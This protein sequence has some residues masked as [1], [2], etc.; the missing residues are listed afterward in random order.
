MQDRKAQPNKVMTMA[1]PYLKQI[2]I[3]LY[4]N[5]AETVVNLQP[6]LTVLVGPNGA[7]K[8]NF[9]DALSFVADCLNYSIQLAFAN[10]GGPT[11]VR[12]KSDQRPIN[13][14]L[15]F[16]IDFGD[17]GWAD[18]AFE[19]QPRSG[20]A[21][22]VARERCVVERFLRSRHEFEVKNGSFVKE[23]PGIR[24]RIESDRLALTIVSAAEEFRP[25]FDF[26]SGIRRY[27]LHPESIRQLQDPDLG[28]GMKLLPDGK[29]AAAVLRRIMEGNGN[30]GYDYER[31]CHLLGK[32]VPGVVSVEPQPFGQKETLKFSQQVADK[33]KWDFEAL[34][35][36]DGTLRAL[37]I[38][39]A[40]YQ[41]Q[42]ASLI[43]IEEP[44]STIHPGATEIL[45]DILLDGT[46]RSQVVITTHSP[47]VLDNKKIVDSQILVAE[48]EEGIAHITP[49]P[50]NTREAIRQ[51]LYSP[52]ELLRNGEVR[53][54]RELANQLAHQVDLFG[55]LE[56]N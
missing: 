16:E 30:N 41:P 15:R 29:N 36:S 23:A 12:R 52:G 48:A 25:V 39:L 6:G 37:G 18:Y 27:T 47:D 26:L 21:F 22:E 14:G 3:R 19:I 20:G 7:G 11:A 56:G 1:R 13:L 10:R 4:K 28:E 44:E 17:D 33:K 24:P 43:A 31:I 38:L 53:V 40:V 32:V 49:L 50:Y 5:I 55:N 8:S 2:Q 51:K 9:V 45:T 35:M 46:N 34:N 42:A 54:D